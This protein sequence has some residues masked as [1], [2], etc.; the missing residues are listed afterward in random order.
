MQILYGLILAIIVAYLAYRAHSL[1]KSGAIAAAFVGTI[2]FGVGGWQWA[3]LL[4]LFFITSIRFKPG[5]QK[6]EARSQ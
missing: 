2:I 5:L 6:T 3:I 4:L 1:D